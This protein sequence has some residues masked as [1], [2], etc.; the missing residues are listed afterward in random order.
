[1]ANTYSQMYDQIVFAVQGRENIIPQKNNRN[2]W[3]F[4]AED[5]EEKTNKRI[6][7]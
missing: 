4:C 6:N 2:K 7:F 5:G 3:Y 1:M